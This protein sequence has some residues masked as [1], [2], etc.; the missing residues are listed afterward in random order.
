M[1]HSPF[2]DGDNKKKRQ[3]QIH[4]SAEGVRGTK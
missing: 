4:L 1:F 2:G 3:N